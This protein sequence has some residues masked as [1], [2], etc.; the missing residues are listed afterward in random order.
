MAFKANIYFT[1]LITYVFNR[2]KTKMRALLLNARQ[3]MS[4]NIGGPMNM[5][6]GMPMAGHA[7]DG[8][9]VTQVMVPAHDPWLVFDPDV[10]T[11]NG[12]AAS[13]ATDREAA[14]RD[15]QDKKR[16]DR[17]RLEDVEVTL[18]LPDR[19]LR[20]VQGKRNGNAIPG[21]VD[22]SADLS[23]TAELQKV[24]GNGA[25]LD[26]RVLRGQP[27]NRL[28]A[29]LTLQDGVVGSYQ[30]CTYEKAIWPFAFLT[31][32]AQQPVGG[33]VQALSDTL[34][35]EIEVPGEELL[36]ETR[37]YGSMDVV[38]SMS[39]RP[40][41]GKGVDLIV[42]NLGPILQDGAKEE[43]MVSHFVMYYTL[44]Q[45]QNIPQRPIPYVHGNQGV[46]P[47][48]HQVVKLPDIFA[49]IKGDPSQGGIYRPICNGL[50]ATAS[51]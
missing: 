39:L 23:W 12:G 45:N 1:G 2:D 26:K 28:T 17:W 8:A 10:A 46:P 49:A 47:E 16:P 18:S 30:M 15:A 19:G 20:V 13:R 35:A 6:G 44:C 38:C 34:R 7:S 27:G 50:T 5:G 14:L 4:M 9:S 32:P 41:K 3:S 36:V 24:V 51:F 42:G 33:Y 25:A 31:A 11:Q 48:G 37:K 21:S 43:T 22:E 40:Q 29:S